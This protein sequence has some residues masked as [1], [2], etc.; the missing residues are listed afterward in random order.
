MTALFYLI[1]T[2]IEIYSFLMLVYVIMGI[3]VSFN[4]I[5]TYNQFVAIVMDTLYKI[6]EPVL[7]P[8]RNLLPSMGGLDFSP[9]IVLVALHALKI[10]VISDIAPALGVY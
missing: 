6:C 10:L 8:I 9:L 3:L 7:R 1:V 5:N 2:A 4:V